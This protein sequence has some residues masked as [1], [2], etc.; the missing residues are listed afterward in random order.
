MGLAICGFVITYL[1]TSIILVA[2]LI[3][4]VASYLP[5][6]YLR[7]QRHRRVV[8]FNTILPDC[9]ENCARSLRAGHSIIAAIDI[10]TELALEPAKTEFGEV[11]KKQ[12]YGLPLRDAL[13]QMLERVPSSDLQVLVTAILVQKD[14]GGNLAEILD[15]AAAVIRDRVRIQGDIRTHT[16]QGRMTGWILFLLP[17]VMMLVINLVNPGYSSVLFK[18]PFGKEMLYGGLAMLLIGGLLIRQIVNGIEV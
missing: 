7:W 13:I 8:A 11:F 3:A 6:G 17:V 18:D 5:V 14:T 9:I 4:A 12:N 16:A 15:R 2:L 10:V 1:V